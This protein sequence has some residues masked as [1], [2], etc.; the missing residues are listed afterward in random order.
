MFSN[1]ATLGQN[2]R[3][4]KKRSRLR[5]EI[6]AYTRCN[7]VPCPVPKRDKRI[8]FNP[9][10]FGDFLP[11]QESFGRGH[12]AHSM[13]KFTSFRPHLQVEDTRE[14][15]VHQNFHLTLANAARPSASSQTRSEPIF[16]RR[17]R[18]KS[19]RDFPPPLRREGHSMFRRRM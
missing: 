10:E 11:R 14:R 17:N 16:S 12:H 15:L 6:P 2:I 3:S 1:C 13:G 4:R 5:T 19:K 8:L 9:N 18:R 7:V